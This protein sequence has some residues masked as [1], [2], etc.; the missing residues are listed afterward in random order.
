MNLELRI[1]WVD[2]DMFGHINNLAIMNYVQSGRVHYLEAVGLMQSQAET[3]IGPILASATCQF[4]KPLFYPGKVRVHST[5]DNVKNTS[6][7]ILHTVYNES[8][9]IIAEAQDIMVVFDF[10]KQVK[11]PIPDQFKKRIERL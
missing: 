7:R 11:T 2:I 8:D 6:F 9:E 3:R 5:G 1:E 4:R 10:N